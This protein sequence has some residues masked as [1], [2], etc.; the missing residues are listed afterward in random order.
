MSIYAMDWA[1]E[2]DIPAN[3]KHTLTVLALHWNQDTGQCNP[4]VARL[5][6]ETG[7]CERTIQRSLQ[8][9]AK[10]GLITP[11]ENLN[12]GRGNAILYRLNFDAEPTQE[13]VTNEPL[14]GDISSIKGDT[15]PALYKG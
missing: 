1:M 5:A 14:K 13:R 8:R 4:G 3:D 2:Q 7:R 11:A 6:K 15:V 9:L 12:G 10:W